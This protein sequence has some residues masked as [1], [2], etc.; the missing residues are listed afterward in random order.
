[1]KV[2]CKGTLECTQHSKSGISGV[3]FLQN[4]PLSGTEPVEPK[5]LFNDKG[6]S[7][8]SWILRYPTIT[9]IFPNFSNYYANSIL[10]TL[11]W[12]YCALLKEIKE[13]IKIFQSFLRQ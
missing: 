12:R 13:V 11:N 6:K 8:N 2:N 7:S 5:I 9:Q 3:S 1:M 4:S 10:C